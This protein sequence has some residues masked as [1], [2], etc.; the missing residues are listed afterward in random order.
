MKESVTVAE[1]LKNEINFFKQTYPDLVDL[2]IV[3]TINL[4][5]RLSNILGKNIQQALPDII[6]ELREKIEEYN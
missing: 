6:K 5:N 1:G 2:G 3:G 4:V